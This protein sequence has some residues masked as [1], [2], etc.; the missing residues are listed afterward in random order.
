MLSWVSVASSQFPGV[1]CLATGNCAFSVTAILPGIY[2]LATHHHA[3]DRSN[4][5]DVA[6]RVF[7]EDDEVRVETRAQ[8][9]QLALAIEKSCR[10]AGRLGDCFERREAALDEQLELAPGRFAACREGHLGV[11]AHHHPRSF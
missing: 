1:V 10:R 3:L 4:R 6:G 8:R 9:A 11:A 5:R 2:P 7:P